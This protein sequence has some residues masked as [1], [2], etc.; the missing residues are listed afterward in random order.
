MSHHW[1][2]GQSSESGAW[3]KCQ[4]WP[5]WRIFLGPGVC[6]RELWLLVLLP[7]PSQAFGEKLSFRAQ[8]CFIYDIVKDLWFFGN[9]FLPKNLA[10]LWSICMQSVPQLCWWPQLTFSWLLFLS[11]FHYTDSVPCLFGN[12]SISNFTHL[13]LFLLL[14]FFFL[15]FFSY[16]IFFKSE[17]SY[18]TI[19]WCFC[20][21]STWIAIRYMY[22]SSL[23]SLP[24]PP[25]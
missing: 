10:G 23:T 7:V 9:I 5:G 14:L 15:F 17:D 12:M 21:K 11:L 16:F 25:L 3:G 24:I 2:W 6:G 20:Q 18:F 8:H 13:L 1:V 4:P 19:L 22:V